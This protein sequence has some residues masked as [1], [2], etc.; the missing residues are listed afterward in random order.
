MTSDYLR[1]LNFCNDKFPE[2]ASLMDLEPGHALDLFDEMSID[3][4]HVTAR[5]LNNGGTRLDLTPWV[6]KMRHGGVILVSESGQEFGDDAAKAWL[7]MSEGLPSATLALAGPI[8]LIQIPLE[9]RA[10]V[11]DLLRSE[12]Q[13]AASLFR[14]MGERLEF[15]QSLGSEHTTAKG[16]RKYVDRML[17]DHLRE[18]QRSEA[19]HKLE[20]ER[21]ET[22]LE[23]S[24]ARLS[25][26]SSKIAGL[27][28][29]GNLLLAELAHY[30]TIN[31]RKLADAQRQGEELARRYQVDIANLQ[32]HLEDRRAEV[33]AMRATRSWR[34]TGPLRAAR[35]AWSQVKALGRRL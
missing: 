9:G 10:P 15:R 32:A 21:L 30:S 23:S 6:Q 17:E 29:E 14:V 33:E 35:R 11:V 24:M 27:Q 8:G 2:S 28:R 18:V 5:A 19:I 3:V 12:K 34:I 26:Q 1:L 4:L 20:V 25:E 7:Q 13:P 22:L 16:I 31:E